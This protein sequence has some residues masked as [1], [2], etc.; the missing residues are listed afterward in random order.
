MEQLE[1]SPL[2]QVAKLLLLELQKHA[3]LRKLLNTKHQKQIT[4]LKR[5]LKAKMTIIVS[6]YESGYIPVPVIDSNPAV[7][8]YRFMKEVE[9]RN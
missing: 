5:R 1:I 2:V 3:A 8:K 6:K 4:F 9:A 7:V